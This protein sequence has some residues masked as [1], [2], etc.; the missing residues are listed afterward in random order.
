[1]LYIISGESE[2]TV[3]LN[4]LTPLYS[5]APFSA[6]GNPNPLIADEYIRERFGALDLSIFPVRGRRKLGG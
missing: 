5:P 6:R 2:E 1:M 3:P 4:T